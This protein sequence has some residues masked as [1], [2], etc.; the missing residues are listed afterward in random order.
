MFLVPKPGTNTWR[1]VMDFRWL[2]THCMKSRC[3]MGTHNKLRRL[4]KPNDRCFRWLNARCL[5]PRCKMETLKKLRRLAKPN[6]RCFRW[7]NARCLKSRCKMESLRKLRRLAKPNDWCFRWLNAR[8]MKSHCKMGTLNKLRRLA[9]PNDR[10][11]RWLNARC[12]KSRCKMGTLKKLRRLAK[13]NGR[14][15]S[16]DQQDSHLMG[17]DKD[18]QEYMQFD[19]WG[20]LF[21][22][23]ALPSG[24]HDLP[25][26]FVKIMRSFLWELTGKVV[27]LYIDNQVVVAMLS[28]FTSRNPELMRRT[29]HLWL[30]LDLNDFELQARYIRSEA[31]EWAHQLSRDKDLDG[32]QLN[33][34]WFKW[35]N[36]KWHKHTVDRFASELSIQLPRH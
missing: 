4:A 27:R 2:S 12:L 15:F 5:K 17:I 1:L 23:G 36:T 20:D 35:A 28:H 24:R 10:C 11:F 19:V 13:P 31:N 30:L 21:Q 16:F 33:R 29:R 7:L 14:C 25:R 6:D 34:Q 9:K 8:C 22:C 18:F 3:Q 32:W 26:I